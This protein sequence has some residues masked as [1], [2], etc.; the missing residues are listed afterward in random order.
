MLDLHYSVQINAPRKKVW[1]VMLEDSTYREWAAVF[2]PGSYYQGDWSEGS[3]MLFLG[4][5]GE[6][7]KDG[8]MAA[9]V[10]E[11]RPEE[12]IS[13]AYHAEIHDGVEVPMEKSG[14]ENYTLKDTEGGT[15]VLVD[16]LNLPDEYA[17]MFNDSWPK[18]LEKLKE[19]VEK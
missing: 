13:L 5:S 3:K 15:E 1:S 2:M 12:F 19:I 17:D 16:L 14:L 8:G 7:K 10:K 6:G 4:P 9:I 11:H 18:A